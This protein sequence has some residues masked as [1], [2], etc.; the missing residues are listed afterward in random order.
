MTGFYKH[1]KKG[2]VAYRA[3]SHDERDFV[4]FSRKTLINVFSCILLDSHS[5]VRY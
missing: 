5:S 3:G 4:L 2:L 1:S